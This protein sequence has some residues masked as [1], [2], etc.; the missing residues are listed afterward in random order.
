MV[1]TGFPWCQTGKK[2]V[3]SRFSESQVH[4]DQVNPCYIARQMPSSYYLPN[5]VYHVSHI[6]FIQPTYL[7]D[8]AA[9]NEQGTDGR[10]MSNKKVSNEDDELVM[11]SQ[12]EIV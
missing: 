4:I 8:L 11:A 9:T 3:C 1:S 2:D 12:R 6:R 5:S 7:S 10:C